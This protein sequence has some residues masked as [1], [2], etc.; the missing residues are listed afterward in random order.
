MRLL[1]SGRNCRLAVL[2]LPLTLLA[3]CGGHGAPSAGGPP[4][5]FAP[6][7][8]VVTLK[9]QPVTLTRELPGRTNA[10]LVAEVRPQV[11]GIL[12]KRL[13]EE[14]SLVKA[15]QPL[16]EI[17]DAIYRAQL[18]SAQATLAKAEAS[19]AA[20]KLTAERDQEL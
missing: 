3:A 17:D 15:G 8:T 2:A 13:F 10:Y 7:V 18:E 14:G 1:N 11:S 6:Q 16:Y 12:K 19:V 4:A 5:G 20:A 9:S